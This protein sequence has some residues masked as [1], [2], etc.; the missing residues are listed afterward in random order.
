MGK[1]A[2]P[3]QRQSQLSAGFICVGLELALCV[4]GRLDVEGREGG[5]K[6][7]AC[8]RIGTSRCNN[9]KIIVTR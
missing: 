5:V 6:G 9:K 3:A 7:P 1:G 8:F 2:C 4:W